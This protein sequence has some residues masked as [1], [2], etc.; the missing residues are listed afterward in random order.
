MCCACNLQGP[1]L[2]G[3]LSFGSHACIWQAANEKL[4]AAKSVLIVGGGAV[5]VEVA[6]EIASVLPDKQVTLVH[7]KR[8]LLVDDK[9]RMSNNAIHWLKQHK[10]NVGTPPKCTCQNSVQILLAAALFQRIAD[11]NN[12]CMVKRSRTALCGCCEHSFDMC[13]SN[14]LWYCYSCMHAC[15]HATSFA[16]CIARLVMQHEGSAI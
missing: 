1:K 3:Q 6:G 2:H 4:R 7:S 15:M 16:T 13:I 12:P 14:P 10:V 8:Q 5:G 9:P 11:L